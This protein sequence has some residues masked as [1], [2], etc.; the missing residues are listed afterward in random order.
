[1]RAAI[2]GLLAALAASL[3]WGVT[4]AVLDLDL[5]LLVIAVGGGWAVGQAVWWGA[6]GEARKAEVTVPERWPAAMAAV[7]GSGVWLGGSFVAYLISLATLPG[8]TLS[9]AERLSSTPF[10]AWLIPQ[11]GVLDALEIALLAILAWRTAR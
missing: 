11:L 4:R 6:W 9:F 3:V 2:A 5:G 10:D 1:V 8:S 7:L